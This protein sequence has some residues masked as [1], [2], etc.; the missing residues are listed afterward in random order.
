MPRDAISLETASTN[1]G[2]NFRFTRL[3]LQSAQ[4]VT[5]A[6]LSAF[7]YLASHGCDRHLVAGYHG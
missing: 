1:T 3:G 2:E 6:V 7:K 4:T 5:A